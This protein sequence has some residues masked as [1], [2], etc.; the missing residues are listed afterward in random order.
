MD[1]N[2]SN[3]GCYTAI[4]EMN[5][6]KICQSDENFLM[7]L[8]FPSSTAHLL[9]RIKGP[10]LGGGFMGKWHHPNMFKYMFAPPQNYLHP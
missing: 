8:E 4:P 9:D 6:R 3:F 2:K 10:G 5:C 1:Q 7:S